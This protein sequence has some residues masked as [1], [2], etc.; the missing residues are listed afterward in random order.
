M[1]AGAFIEQVYAALR[2]NQGR[3]NIQKRAEVSKNPAWPDGSP[4]ACP[5]SF[6][7]WR[8]CSARRLLNH[9]LNSSPA[10]IS[11]AVKWA[12]TRGVSGRNWLRRL[13]IKREQHIARTIGQCAKGAVMSLNRDFTS[14]FECDRIMGCLVT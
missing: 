12:R 5:L 3:A 11:R 1:N 2:I 13:R 14:I 9:S 4:T 10:L 6:A 7:F 8:I